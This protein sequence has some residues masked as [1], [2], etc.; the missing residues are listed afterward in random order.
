MDMIITDGL[1]R[2]TLYREVAAATTG[3]EPFT[4]DGAIGFQPPG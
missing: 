2:N 1:P 4:V 3:N